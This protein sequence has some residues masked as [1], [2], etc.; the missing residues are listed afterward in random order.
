[1]SVSNLLEI[2]Q[3]TETQSEKMAAFNTAMNQ[4]EKVVA[5]RYI[6]PSSGVN[7]NDIFTL[8]YDDSDDLSDRTA[9]RFIYC[10]IA[11]GA[12][13]DF[14]V[15][16]PTAVHFFFVRNK[17]GHTATF[18]VAGTAGNTVDVPPYTGQILYCDGTAFT[19]ILISSAT[20]A[21]DVSV[22]FWGT[23]GPSET[24]AS[25]LLARDT[26]FLPD[27]SG[28]QV[29]LSSDPSSTYVMEV[30][31]NVTKIGEISIAFN[32][33]VTAT[34]VGGTEKTVSAGDRLRVVAPPTENVSISNIRIAIPG[35][36][37]L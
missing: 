33:A 35:T 2:L 29:T 3:I 34:T 19:E 28:I 1:M 11:P 31:S 32:G 4:M 15:I 26:D 17:T 25:I 10:E 8:P 37:T 27:F 16:H 24:I 13:D 23:P 5:G 14:T 18:K 9:L 7:D 21:A 36:T 20:S 6:L 22:S 30:F 12:T